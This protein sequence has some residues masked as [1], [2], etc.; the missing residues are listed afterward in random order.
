MIIDGHSHACGDY[1][2]LA[3][4]LATIDKWGVDKVILVPGELNSNTNYSL[5]NFAKLFPNHNV[6]KIAN[7]I[8]KIA[9]RLTGKVKEIPAGN[10]F[11]YDLTQESHGR[12][13][14]FIWITKQNGNIIDFLDKKYSEWGFHGV[15]LHQ[16]WE[17]FS[18]D[19]NFFREV[20]VWTEKYDLP[21]FIHPD[22]DTEVLKI[23]DYKRK[24]PKLKL[25]I[26]HLF[27]LELFIKHKFKDDNL[28]FDSSCPQ[29]I[30]A[31]RLMD[32]IQFV[33]VDKITFGTDSPYGKGNIDKYM[34]KIK[35]L[36]I[37]N[38][39]RDMILGEN[40]RKL[41]KI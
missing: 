30:S 24:H 16:C 40:M 34:K 19:S 11:V 3:N 20:A 14:Q 37:S 36:N 7:F 32:A 12:I 4:L 27:G 17:R 41:L 23:I 33:G 29:L 25:I 35:N 18:V 31:K 6:V 8:S 5:P 26:A 2:T 21:L 9:I 28:Y 1:L 22:S 10:K 13:I 39:D 38:Q 15:K